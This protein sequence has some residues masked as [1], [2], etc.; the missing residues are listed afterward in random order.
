MPG[1]PGGRVYIVNSP[2]LR[3]A[4]LR[5]PQK[6]SARYVE[7]RYTPALAGLSP[8]ATKT[9]AHYVEVGEQG[10]S[11]LKEGMEA[12]QRCMNLGEPLTSAS[13]VA[14]QKLAGA[15]A[16]LE[17]DGPAAIDLQRWIIDTVSVTA[18]DS[19]WGPKN[20]YR[21][22]EIQKGFWYV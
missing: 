12:V 9:L 14:V 7:A 21:D 16:A 18:T 8:G 15:V 2:D 5:A 6:F 10:Q 11:Y 4:V 13:R 17:K 19:I 22:P 1:M 20:P 3:A